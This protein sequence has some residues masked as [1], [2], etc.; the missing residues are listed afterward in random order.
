MEHS[1][2]RIRRKPG[3]SQGQLT[4][5]IIMFQGRLGPPLVKKGAPTHA[6]G[7]NL[8]GNLVP[9][10]PT[11]RTKD[12]RQ[13]TCT[14]AASKAR[15]VF[16][17][18]CTILF[19]LLHFGGSDRKTDRQTNGHQLLT[20]LVSSR[21]FPLLSSPLLVLHFSLGLLGFVIL[22]Y[23]WQARACRLRLRHVIFGLRR[24]FSCF[25]LAVFG[26]AQIHPHKAPGTAPNIKC[27]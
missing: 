10:L 8:N 6:L 9:C 18:A 17:A 14:A 21:E 20:C 1:P 26:Q 12:K 13:A 4:V 22:A 27:V 16:W 5:V 2:R 24:L 15:L 11:P 3:G 23:A 7:R 25:F 19:L